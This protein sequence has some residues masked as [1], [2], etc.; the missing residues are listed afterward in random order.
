MKKK[1]IIAPI[2]H[3]NG[4]SKHELTKPIDDALEAIRHAYDAL[5]QCGPNGRDYYTHPKA[6]QAME[7]A[8]R[9]HR[10]RM[11]TL[12]NLQTELESLWAAIE[13]QEPT[14]AFGIME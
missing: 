9:E 8:Q 7:Q 3:L 10:E 1:T 12:H 6:P 2:V 11:L 14:A 13:D 5:K 4:T